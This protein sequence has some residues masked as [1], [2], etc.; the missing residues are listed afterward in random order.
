M[1]SEGSIHTHKHWDHAQAEE[2][3]ENDGS[4]CADL[5]HCHCERI[6]NCPFLVYCA[7]WNPQPVEIVFPHWDYL[8]HVV[9]PARQVSAPRII[10]CG[11]AAHQ[12]RLHIE[13]GDDPL[14]SGQENDGHVDL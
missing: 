9:S 14:D 12:Q 7:Q 11:G 3:K 4:K 8:I 2:G 5:S 13:K 10:D 1:Y 6:P